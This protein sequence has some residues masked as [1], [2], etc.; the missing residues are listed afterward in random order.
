MQGEN[1]TNKAMIVHKVLTGRPAQNQT[2][3]IAFMST[4]KYPIR[5]YG[6]ND[7][8]KMETISAVLDSAIFTKNMFKG[9]A[10]QHRN[11]EDRLVYNNNFDVD[12]LRN[13]LKSVTLRSELVR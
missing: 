4:R 1:G 10:E 13:L 6:S 2:T 5:F 11:R 8:V 3:E 7:I 12:V 9:G